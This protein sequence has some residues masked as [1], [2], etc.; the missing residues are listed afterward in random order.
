V[1]VDM[2]Q[3][4]ESFSQVNGNFRDFTDLVDNHLS[5]MESLI[6]EIDHL[7]QSFERERELNEQ[8]LAT[9]LKETDYEDWSLEGDRINNLIDKFTIFIHKKVMTEGQD[10]SGVH[11]DAEQAQASEITLF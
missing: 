11:L 10:E 7:S 8:E 2:D 4:F 9:L 6:G 5:H 1:R 3:H